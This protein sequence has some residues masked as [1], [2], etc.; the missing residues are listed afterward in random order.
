MHCYTKGEISN[1]RMSLLFFRSARVV[2]MMQEV[3]SIV[4]GSDDLPNF[5]RPYF[6]GILNSIDRKLLRSADDSCRI[7][8]LR[9]IVHVVDMIGPHLC[10]FVPKIMALLTQTLQEPVLQEEGLRVW[11]SFVRTLARVVSHSCVSLR[12]RS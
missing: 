10:G 5:L 1:S 7:K 12:S 4:T 3:A 11:L 9:C 8:G 6:V 2:P